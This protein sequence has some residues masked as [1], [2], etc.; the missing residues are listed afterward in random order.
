MQ[1][2]MTHAAKSDVYAYIFRANA[3]A[4]NVVG[5]QVLVGG[6]GGKA[7]GKCQGIASLDDGFVLK[8]L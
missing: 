4:L 7:G 8:K 3:S 5:D 6:Q 2:G 1:I